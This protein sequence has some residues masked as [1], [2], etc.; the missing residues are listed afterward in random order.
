MFLLSTDE[1]GVFR[2]LIQVFRLVAFVTK[3][4]VTKVP[5]VAVSLDVTTVAAAVAQEERV[6]LDLQT[7]RLL[8]VTSRTVKVKAYITMFVV[9]STS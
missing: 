3:V 6:N 7:Q 4:F 8:S 5:A 2:L 1:L 9:V